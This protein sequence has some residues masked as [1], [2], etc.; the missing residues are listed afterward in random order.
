MPIYLEFAPEG[1][2]GAPD[3]A[4]SSAEES[5]DEDKESRE[6]DGFYCS[7]AKTDEKGE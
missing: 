6:K 5:G 2:I 1:I 3:K 4:E 7:C